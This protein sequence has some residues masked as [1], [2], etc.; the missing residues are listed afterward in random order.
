MSRFLS[1]LAVALLCIPVS[2]E[3]KEKPKDPPPE[4]REKIDGKVDRS[5]TG[6][7]EKVEAKEESSGVLVVRTG[8][9]QPLYR[10]QIDAKTKILTNKGAPLAGGLSSPLIK[11]V[12]APRIPSIRRKTRA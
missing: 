10:F 3:E 8:E 9:D 4:L 7:V 2:A 5:L 12:L 1:G 6:H 11:S